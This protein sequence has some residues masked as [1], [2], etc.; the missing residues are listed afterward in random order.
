M[1]KNASLI[2]I[3][4]V[5]GA[6]SVGW[7]TNREAIMAKQEADLQKFMSAGPRFTGYDGQQ[8]CERVKRLEQLSIGFRKAGYKPLD[9]NYGARK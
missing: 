6:L 2:F 4:S 3:F 1:V 7:W 8:L 5:L 9:C